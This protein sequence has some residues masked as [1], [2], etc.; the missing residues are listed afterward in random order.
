MSRNVLKS[1]LL[2][3]NSCKRRTSNKLRFGRRW[4]RRFS[5]L[6]RTFRSSVN[7]KRKQSLSIIAFPVQI[8]LKREEKRA[9]KQFFNRPNAAQRDPI[10]Q[11]KS[12]KTARTSERDETRPRVESKIQNFPQSKPMAKRNPKRYKPKQPTQAI[13][14]NLFPLL[15][16]IR[17]PLPPQSLFQRHAKTYEPATKQNSA[18]KVTDNP[19][20][21]PQLLQPTAKQQLHALHGKTDDAYLATSRLFWSLNRP[22]GASY[23]QAWHN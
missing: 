21:Q 20:V 13:H 9:E 19:R 8:K 3:K 7:Y 22:H 4:R 16:P 14:Q 6:R 11:H 23:K 10:Q 18:K 17:H 15:Q 5:K 12:D 2:C 1:F